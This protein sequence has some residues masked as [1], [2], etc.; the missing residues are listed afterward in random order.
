MVYLLIKDNRIENIISWDGVTPYTLPKDHE[1][2][3]YEGVYDLYWEW[4][5]VNHRPIAPPPEPPPVVDPSKVK[6]IE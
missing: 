3:E 4:D 5:A 6:I 2:V 1:L